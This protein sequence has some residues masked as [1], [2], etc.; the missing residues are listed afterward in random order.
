MSNFLPKSRTV[1]I[2]LLIACCTANTQA[3]D[4]ARD[5]PHRPV[6]LMVTFPAGGGIDLIARTVGQKLADAWGQQFV[7]DNRAGGG[8]VIG[9]EIVARAA[10]DGYNLLLAS[11]TGFI[12]SPLLIAKLPYD[13]FKDFSPVTLIAIN[14]TILCVHPSLPVTTVKELIAHA[15]AKPRQL[16]YASAG[17]GSPIHLGMEMFKSMTATDMLHVPYKGSV[18]AVTDLLAGQVQVMLN[19]M[20]TMLPHVKSGKLRALAVGSARRA[21]AVPDLVTIA[22]AGVPGF[23]AVAW[24]GLA[25]PANTPAPIIGKL[26]REVARVLGDADVAQRLATQGAEAQSSTPEGFAQ[27]MREESARARK[28][29]ASAG[30]KSE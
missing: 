9:T 17:N 26:N 22:E 10:P 23:E 8:G 25:A 3:A 6:R 12:I 27:F 18:P 11:G 30:I 21:K 15:R 29:I 7:I 16:N 13:P 20:P 5:Y 2:G 4:T 24:A 1:I 19:S 28:V 14:P